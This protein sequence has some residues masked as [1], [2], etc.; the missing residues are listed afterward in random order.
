MPAHP[1][2]DIPDLHA[3]EPDPQHAD[4]Q[5]FDRYGLALLLTILFHVLLVVLVRLEMRPRLLPPPLATP[6]NNNNAISVN[7]YETPQA[8]MAAPAPPPIDLPP[9]RTRE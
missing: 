4:E 1:E 3:R 7:L 9:V 5:P 6:D 8:S 2:R